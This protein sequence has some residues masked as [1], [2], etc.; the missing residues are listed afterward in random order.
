MIRIMKAPKPDVLVKNAEAWTKV[1]LDQLKAGTLPSESQKSRYRHREIKEALIAET[2]GKCAY[3]ESKLRHI[4]YGDVEHIVP[5]STDPAK[6]FEWEN[7]TLACDV[8]NTNKADHFEDHADLVDPYSVDP[9]E[10][11]IF[12]G[13]NIL[14]KPGSAPGL[15]T[16]S[17]LKLN[18]LELLERRSEKLMQLNRQLQLLFEVSD[19][20]KRKVIRRDLEVHE[21]SSDK[22]FAG[23]AR[24]YIREALKKID[25][26]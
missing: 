16:E 12:A 22:E 26:A 2:F 20:G 21:L 19:P 15:A 7:L 5:K 4:T 6:T 13:A 18:R 23:M 8:C 11:L 9:E 3:C 25:A 10:H 17:T 1:V 14:P 24:T